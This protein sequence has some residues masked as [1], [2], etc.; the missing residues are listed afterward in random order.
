MTHPVDFGK[1][2]PL[3]IFEI[4]ADGKATLELSPIEDYAIEGTE[5]LT[6]ILTGSSTGE[7]DGRV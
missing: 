7:T 2:S 6:I 5:T 1:I 3:G 4:G